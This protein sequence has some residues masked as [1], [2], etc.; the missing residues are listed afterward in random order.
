M[1]KYLI[2]G[3]LTVAFVTP[4]L[5]EDFYVAVDLASGRCVMMGG[6]APDTKFFK[7]MGKY[8][9]HEGRAQSHGRHERVQIASLAFPSV[10]QGASATSGRPLFF[11]VLTLSHHD[12]PA[13][14][15]VA[16]AGLAPEH[17]LGL[18]LLA[19]ELPAPFGA[20]DG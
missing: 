16:V 6:A 8:D 17:E 9:S 10:S 18:A 7:S 1:R 20:A 4:A 14:S 12:H 15:A 19:F 2:A 13:A 3:L 5:A 11:V